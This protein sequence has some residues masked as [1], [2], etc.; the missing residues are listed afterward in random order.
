MARKDNQDGYSLI[1]ILGVV[2]LIGIVSAIALPMSSRA[3]GGLRLRGDGRAVSNMVALAKMRAASSFSRA[4]LFADLSSN[5]FFLQTWDK[6]AGDW[7]TEGG[8]VL[9]SSGVSFG[10]GTL[11]TAPPNTQG[12]LGQSPACRDKDGVVIANTACVVFN[13]RGIPIDNAG[14]PTAA[15]ALYVT[16]GVGVFGTTLTATPLIRMWW[17]PGGSA[18]WVAQ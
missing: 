17:S 11:S 18:G 5:S 4:R 13:S 7:A 16:D 15:N 1:E 2:G 3:V 14:A 6:D 10:V 8:A 12:T 9:L